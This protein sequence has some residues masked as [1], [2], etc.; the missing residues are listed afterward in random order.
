MVIAVS[1][2]L[3]SDNTV[4]PSDIKCAITD[5]SSSGTHIFLILLSF[6][7][8]YPLIKQYI[9]FITI[10]QHTH[11]LLT[12]TNIDAATSITIITSSKTTTT[13]K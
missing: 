3:S 5:L 9:I 8:I 13:S 10:T 11:T 4:Y 7:K 2:S 1:K 12:T 6:L